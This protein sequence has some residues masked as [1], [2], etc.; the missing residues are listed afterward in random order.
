MAHSHPRA[1]LYC[2]MPFHCLIM[3]ATVCAV[4]RGY[5]LALARQSGARAG[6]S[7]E[8]RPRRREVLEDRAGHLRRHRGEARRRTRPAHRADR[9][10]RVQPLR[11][12]PGRRQRPAVPLRADRGG[13]R[14]GRRRLAAGEPR[15]S[16]LVAGDEILAGAVRQRRRDASSR[17]A[18]IA[19][20]RPPRRRRRARRCCEA[21][22]ARLLRAAESETDPAV[23]EILRE[24]ALRAADRRHLVVG[25]LRQLRGQAGGR[26]ART[27]SASPMPTAPTSTTRLR[28]ARPRWTRPPTATST[29]RV[30]SRR[31]GPGSAT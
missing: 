27:R 14:G 6:R 29:G 2:G 9:D 16:R 1:G 3:R 12:P 11:R 30:R 25:G 13:A 26:R 19:T 18:A 7:R 17:R 21:R 22:R 10:R 15:P 31:P 5:R 8:A 23:R 4:V 28:P 24:A 20:P